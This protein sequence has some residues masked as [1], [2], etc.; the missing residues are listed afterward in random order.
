MKVKVVGATKQTC[1][2]LLPSPVNSLSLIFLCRIPMPFFFLSVSYQSPLPSFPS[3]LNWTYPT[4]L[5]HISTP[6]MCSSWPAHHFSV[7]S[8]FFLLPPSPPPLPSSVPPWWPSPT[9]HPAFCLQAW[10]VFRYPRTNVFQTWWGDKRQLSST[11]LYQ[12]RWPWPSYKVAV[13]WKIKNFCI[14]FLENLS[15]ALHAIQSAATTCWF[16]EAHAKFI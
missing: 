10:L 8:L 12:F 9:I 5:S 6:P 1:M 11:F 3:L 13:V 2:V 15:I 16:V 4:P 14:H 7:C